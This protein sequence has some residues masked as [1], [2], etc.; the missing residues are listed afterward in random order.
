[1][2]DDVLDNGF[3][4]YCL[5]HIGFTL[6]RPFQLTL[7]FLNNLTWNNNFVILLSFQMWSKLFYH[8]MEEHPTKVAVAQEMQ[9][10]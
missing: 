4:L 2:Q 8:N 7:M 6:Y 1:M 10:S 3:A 9:N 5:C